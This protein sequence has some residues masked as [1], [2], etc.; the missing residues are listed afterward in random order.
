MPALVRL[1]PLHIWGTDGAKLGEKI[2]GSFQPQGRGRW[3]SWAASPCSISVPQGR[4][5]FPHYITAPSHLTP[6][7]PLCLVP[8]SPRQEAIPGACLIEAFPVPVSFCI[9]FILHCHT[10]LPIL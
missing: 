8:F 6:L 4:G 1:S 3:R 9:S 10:L 5:P 7:W 2:M